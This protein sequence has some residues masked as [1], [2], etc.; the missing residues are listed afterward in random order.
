MI[1]VKVDRRALLRRRGM[2]ALRHLA[3]AVLLIW[4]GLV[5]LHPQPPAEDM[6]VPSAPASTQAEDERLYHLGVQQ[7][8]DDPQQAIITLTQAAALNPDRAAQIA[9]LL[10]ALNARAADAPELFYLKLGVAYLRLDE[11]ALAEIALERAVAIN[12]A[13]GEATAYLAYVRARLGKPA[14]G[15]AQQALALDPTNPTVYYLVGLTWKQ[16]GRPLEARLAF[17]RG[18]EL[19]PTNPAFPIEIAEVHR[20]ERQYALAELWMKEAV[21]LAPQ[22]FRLR[23]LL[24]QFYVDSEYRVAEEGLALAQAL[25]AEQPE[26]AEAHATL[27]WA[28]FLV[29]EVGRAFEEMDR[30]LVLD[31]S[32]PRANAHMGAL[33]ESQGRLD[34]AMTYYERAQ[35]LDPSGPFGA[36]AARALE[37]IAGQ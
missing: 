33:L 12:P 17:E 37:R 13:Y 22:D 36:L 31:P 8:L 7:A 29:G 3:A 21:R 6:V 11:I 15:A 10:E 5:P 35:A 19:D 16:I 30:A 20:A 1:S 34:E 25:A 32:L 26:S 23:L 24:A 4:L 14:L 28:Y 27:G 2:T 18:Y 9:A